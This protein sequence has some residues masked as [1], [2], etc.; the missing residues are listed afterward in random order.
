MK[1]IY[2]GECNA[3]DMYMD[4][5]GQLCPDHREGYLDDPDVMNDLEVEQKMNDP[6][7]DDKAMDDYNQK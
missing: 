6:F 1:N 5:I 4:Q 2:H 3:C 7:A